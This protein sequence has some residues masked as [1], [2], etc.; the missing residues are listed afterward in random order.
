MKN[1]LCID[2]NDFVNN[3]LNTF[4]NITKFLNFDNSLNDIEFFFKNREEKIYKRN[5]MCK[6]IKERLEMD[7]Y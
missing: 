1:V 7:L 3:P 5:K 2:Y 4:Y 6:I